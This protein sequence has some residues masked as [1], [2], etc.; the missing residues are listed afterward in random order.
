MFQNCRSHFTRNTFLN[1]IKSLDQHN[2]GNKMLCEFQLFIFHPE[3]LDQVSKRTPFR[4]TAVI[5]AYESDK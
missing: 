5:A 3:S 2:E 1:E 4:V